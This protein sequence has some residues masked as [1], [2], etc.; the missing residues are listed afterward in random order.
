[1]AGMASGPKVCLLGPGHVG[2]TRFVHSHLFI[3][4]VEMVGA[5]ALDVALRKFEIMERNENGC[6]K[7]LLVL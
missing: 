7:S 4:E 6:Q 1:M 2:H 3:P 5:I